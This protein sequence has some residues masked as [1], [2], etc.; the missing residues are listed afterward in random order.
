VKAKPPRVLLFDSFSY[1]DECHSVCL[2][3]IGK[4]PALDTITTEH[5]VYRSI[6]FSDAGLIFS[7]IKRRYGLSFDVFFAPIVYSSPSYWL[8]SNASIEA[9][10]T[11]SFHFRRIRRYVSA[12]VTAL[13]RKILMESPTGFVIAT[14]DH[15]P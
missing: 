6:L 4:V 13:G 1:E 5:S 3:W 8:R 14:A 7:T 9:Q 10:H 12:T 2:S 15:L 11:Q